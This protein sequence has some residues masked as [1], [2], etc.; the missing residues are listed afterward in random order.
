[1]NGQDIRPENAVNP[2]N[3]KIFAPPHRWACRPGSGALCAQSSGRNMTRIA[4]MKWIPRFRPFKQAWLGV[5]TAGGL[6][7][8]AFP[9]GYA[10]D[11]PADPAGA[12]APPPRP[13]MIIQAETSCALLVIND[14]NNKRI[15]TGSGFFVTTNGVLL[16]NYHVIQGGYSGYIR[17]RDGRSHRIGHVLAYSPAGDLALLQTE[18]KDSKPMVIAAPE[19]TKIGMRV[20][21][22]GAPEGVSWVCTSGKVQGFVDEKGV[23]LLQY[24]ASSAPGASG[25]P[26]FDDEG[27]VHA[28]HA[29][30]AARTIRT[31]DGRYQ[32]DWSKPQP[33]GIHSAH[34]LQLLAA[35][36]KPA[37]LGKIGEMA[38]RGS[39]ANFLLWACQASDAVLQAMCS[40]LQRRSIRV[41]IRTVERRVIGVGG[42]REA[43][44][45]TAEVFVPNSLQSISGA[46]QSISQISREVAADS[47]SGD[48]A[49]DRA[50]RDWHGAMSR[51]DEA[52][53]TFTLNGSG[54]PEKVKSATSNLSHDIDQVNTMFLSALKQA[55]LSYST[56]Q[57]YTSEDPLFD[58]DEIRS[59]HAFYSKDGL[60]IDAE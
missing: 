36:R 48:P 2:Q 51:A 24:T 46:I 52:I 57:K 21:L 58:A 29:M 6:A 42:Q 35:P 43:R 1:M 50:Y 47:A 4:I 20:H 37:P 56:Y 26:V 33:R 60:R 39:K 31:S 40:D 38:N 8:F 55:Q 5:A 32:L 11:A 23:M 22:M 15:G 44:I 28:V 25:S 7:F 34:I 53:R 54:S 14:K 27:R 13:D 49:L 10:A 16:T 9:P 3:E 18:C 19:E 30:A 12:A 45:R 41:N 17:T 59:I